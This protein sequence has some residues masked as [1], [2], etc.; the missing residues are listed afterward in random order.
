MPLSR[1]GHIKL[2]FITV[3]AAVLSGNLLAQFSGVVE[4]ELVITGGWL[5]DGISEGR[6]PNTGIVIRDGKFIAVGLGASVAISDS[7]LRI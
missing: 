2:F 1:P 7:A 4:N 5:F 3:L 6:K